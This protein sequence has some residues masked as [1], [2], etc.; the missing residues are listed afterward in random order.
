[1]IINLEKTKEIVIYRPLSLLSNLFTRNTNVGLQ[2]LAITLETR[3][4]KT[5]SKMEVQIICERSE[6]EKL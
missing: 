4:V 3:A 5:N 1:M 2:S 6:L